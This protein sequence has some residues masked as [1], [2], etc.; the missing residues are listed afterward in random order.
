MMTAHIPRRRKRRTCYDRLRRRWL[1]TRRARTSNP[2][3]SA[4]LQLL[5]VFSFLSCRMPIVVSTPVPYI[6]PPMSPGQAQR[7][8]TARRLGVPV[9]YLDLVLSRGEVPYS[10]LFDHIRQGGP[11]RRDA[12][13]E[14]R[15]K[16]PE[17][18]LDWLSHIERRGLWSDLTR[19]FHRYGSA[20]D[21]DVSL[22]KSTLAWLEEQQK[23]DHSASGP[24]DMDKTLTPV[25]GVEEQDP[26]NDP[27]KPKL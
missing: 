23:P 3:A 24:A 22:L 7:I 20:E 8:D 18:A 21:T 16:V 15:K 10:V 14:L 4:V 12:M 11:A 27:N 6:A 17:A 5:G 25:A 13:N 1:E 9:R 2:A 19:C 26:D